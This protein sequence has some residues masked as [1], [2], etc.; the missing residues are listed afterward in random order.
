MTYEVVW[1][2]HALAAAAALAADDR[3]GL[4]AVFEAT[5]A[6]AEDPHPAGVRRWGRDVYRLRVGRYRVMYEVDDG[7]VV[8]AV[9]HLGHRG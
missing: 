4:L 1:S 2:S 7:R 3:E 9:F 6:L 8:I 5:D